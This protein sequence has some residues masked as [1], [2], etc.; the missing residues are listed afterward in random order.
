MTMKR[1][2]VTDKGGN[3]KLALFAV[4]TIIK[5]K[6]VRIL[7]A[8]LVERNTSQTSVP[9]GL[10]SKVTCGRTPRTGCRPR[11]SGECFVYKK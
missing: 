11:G 4:L 5:Q 8:S 9:T 10:R 6:I 7:L 3:Q 1:K 2:K